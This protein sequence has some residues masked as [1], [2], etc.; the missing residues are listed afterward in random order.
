L[1]F[2]FENIP[3]G[4]PALFRRV[5][6]IS[7]KCHHGSFY[8]PELA[9]VGDDVAGQDALDRDP[10]SAVL[11]RQAFGEPANQFELVMYF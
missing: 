8:L 1:A 11:V 2:W 6:F 3:S 4:N 5:A 9:H 7:Q 10:L